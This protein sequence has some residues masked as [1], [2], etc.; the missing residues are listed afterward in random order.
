[1]PEFR[2]IHY[3][4]MIRD[5]LVRR[6]HLTIMNLWTPAHIGTAGNELAD[7]AAKEAT[8]QDPDPNNFVSLT[9]VRRSIHLHILDRW[10]ALWKSSK[11]GRALRYIDKSPP[12][13]IPIPLYSSSSL[14]RKT[15]SSLA[16]LR[17]DFSYLNAHRFKSGFVASPA[18]EDCGAPFE[19]RAH[20]I[21]EC[22]AW[23]LHRQPLH[24][25]ARKVGI[26]GTLHLSPL[27]THPKLL[28]SM[29]S[30]VEATGRFA[31]PSPPS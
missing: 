2:A 14:S 8:E 18:C 26:F 31:R 3:D 10:D 11:V 15:S 17:T 27:L 30:F 19:T 25:A 22:P 7:A 20:Y 12:S 16:Q 21:L 5:A 13:L 1:M 23:E 9:S 4:K 28:A 29:G 6:P 24:A